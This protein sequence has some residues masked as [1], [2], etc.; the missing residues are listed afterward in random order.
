[1]A[2]PGEL[3]TAFLALR[4]YD[5]DVQ[6]VVMPFDKI[7]EAVK[8]AL[9]GIRTVATVPAATPKEVLK[10]RP[11]FTFTASSDGE[12]SSPSWSK[13]RAFLGSRKR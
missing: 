4:L 7:Q 3:T 13:R 6:T 10:P 9:L 5:P 12:A 11:G 8:A 1:M 2:I